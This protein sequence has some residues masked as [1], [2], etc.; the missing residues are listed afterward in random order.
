MELRYVPGNPAAVTGPDPDAHGA[1]PS[2][3]REPA[4]RPEDL[5][6]FFIERANAGDLEGLVALYE[7]HAVLALPTGDVARGKQAIRDAFRPM[8]AEQPVFTAGHGK[9]ALLNGDLALTWSRL[10]G[11]ATAEIA[12]RQPDGT[13][14][15]TVDQPYIL[16]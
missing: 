9:P 4:R 16:A 11:G 14:L 5:S 13:W 1:P 8:L 12:R 6:R 7:P 2:A 15:W 3:D 10:P